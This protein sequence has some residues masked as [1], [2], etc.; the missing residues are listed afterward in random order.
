[1]S[2]NNL[3]MPLNQCLQG[4]SKRAG[5]ALNSASVLAPLFQE[6]LQKQQVWTCL[7]VAKSANTMLGTRDH[8]L[9]HASKS[10]PAMK[11]EGKQSKAPVKMGLNSRSKMGSKKPKFEVKRASNWAP[12]MGQNHPY[13][14]EWWVVS[15]SMAVFTV[16]HFATFLAHISSLDCTKQSWCA[17]SWC[18]IH[19]RWSGQSKLGFQPTTWKVSEIEISKV[20]TLM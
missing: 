1:M 12:N 20:Q 16:A 18:I 14:C 2:Q 9:D 10:W 17:V 3:E 5:N 7:E 6:K 4:D 8:N 13:L 19:F 15:W 11:K